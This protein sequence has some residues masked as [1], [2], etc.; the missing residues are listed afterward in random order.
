MHA[1]DIP[2]FTKLK[3]RQPGQTT[4]DEIAERDLKSELDARERI[5]LEKIGKLDDVKMLEQNKTPGNLLE[6]GRGT[7]RKLDDIKENEYA[8]LDRDDSDSDDES[9][10][11]SDD[12]NENAEL[13][14]ELER[15]KAEREVDAKRRKKE[16]AEEEMERDQEQTMSGNPLLASQ[17]GDATVK[18]KWYEQVVFKNQTR[19]E[20]DRKK[21]RFI[22]DT[23][24]NDFHKRFLN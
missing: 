8:A 5:H 3:M 1:R 4:T 19:G 2:G 14:R 12:E 23:I 22:N 10:F 18:K 15:I 20:P 21:K 13:I 9:S 16:E 7:K 6:D 11:D 24:R 17:G